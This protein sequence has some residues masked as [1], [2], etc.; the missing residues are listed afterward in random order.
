MYSLD[1]A[2]ATRCL[3]PEFARVFCLNP[4]MVCHIP[5]WICDDTTSKFTILVIFCH[6]Q[7]SPRRNRLNPPHRPRDQVVKLRGFYTTVYRHD[8]FIHYA[9]GNDDE[10]DSFKLPN[11]EGS[12]TPVGDLG[13]QDALENMLHAEVAKVKITDFVQGEKDELE[14]VADQVHSLPNPRFLFVLRPSRTPCATSR[15]TPRSFHVSSRRQS[16]RLTWRE[17]R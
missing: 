2:H 6:E 7:C 11:G 8:E 4:R 12:S 15:P 13:L 14:Q 1:R 17:W 3:V 16:L 9:G 10:L 5:V